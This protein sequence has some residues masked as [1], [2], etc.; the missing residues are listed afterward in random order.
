MFYVTGTCNSNCDG[1]ATVTV[2]GYRSSVTYS[3][4]DSAL[5]VAGYFADD[6]SGSGLVN[7]TAENV[8]SGVAKVVMTSAGTGS[9]TNYSVS[10]CSGQGP[11]KPSSCSPMTGGTNAYN[12]YDSGSVTVTVNSHGSPAASYG[13]GSSGASVAQTLANNINGDGSASVTASAS[14]NVVTLTAKTTGGGTNY[15]LAVTQQSNNPGHFNPPSFTMGESGG[16]LTGGA[17][18]TPAVYD[19]G[20]AWVTVNG[21]LGTASYGQ[22]DTATTVAANVAA[23]VNA[24]CGTWATAA[25]SG[26]AVSVTAKATGTGSDYSLSAG[27]STSQPGSFSHA[28]FAV[29]ASGGALT[30]GS[31]GTTVYDTGTAWVTVNGCQGTANYGQSDTAATVASSVAAAVN[32]SCGTWVTAAANGTTVGLTAAQTGGNTNYSLSAGSATSQPGSF[33]G[34]SFSVGASGGNLVSGTNPTSYGY[35]L[36]YAPDGDVV[37]ANDSVNGIWTYTYDDFNRLVSSACSANCPDGQN[38]QGFG[39]V[40]DRYA[41]RWQQNVTA[42]S[43]PQPVATFNN[44]K[45]QLDGY[46]Y[47]ADGNLL[48]DGVHS[49]TYDAESRIVAVDGGSAATYVYDAGGRRVQKTTAGGTVSYVYD[50]AGN[51]VAE[52]NASGGANRKEVYAGGR[53]V[54][55]YTN[56]TTYF[57]HADWLGTE[58]DADDGFWLGVRDDCELGVWRRDGDD[59]ELQRRQPDAFYRQAA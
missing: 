46:S 20:S 18:G 5:T 3:D 56:G 9:G 36:T 27:S 2:G 21:C 15:A 50:I 33:S 17:N 14:G 55:T 42:G 26:T 34:P 38:T 6:L 13:Q 53:H 28:S 39:Y 58:A 43:G 57:D 51:Q 24:S 47:D 8:T 23:A 40:Y 52:V 49:Y 16:S 22:S 59:G 44:A 29:A 31:N 4:G 19:T 45:N 1:S 48:Y 12:V 11:F 35:A 25:A 54:A 37:A 10:S 30:G 7:A 41:N 32:A